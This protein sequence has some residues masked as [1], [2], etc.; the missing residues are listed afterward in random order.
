MNEKIAKALVQDLIRRGDSGGTIQF[1]DDNS[2]Y[3]VSVIRQ[4]ESQTYLRE[5]KGLFVSVGAAGGPCGCC[6]GSGRSST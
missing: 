1:H 6:N 4:A 5:S 2:V 3:T